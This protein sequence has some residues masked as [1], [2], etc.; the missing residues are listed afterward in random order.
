MMVDN[1]THSLLPLPIVLRK[2]RPFPNILSILDK[3]LQE[4]IAADIRRP[5]Q[6]RVIV[7]LDVKARM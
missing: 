4:S 1:N 3:G 5:G 6:V 2:R 7:H